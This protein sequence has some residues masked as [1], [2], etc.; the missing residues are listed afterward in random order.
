SVAGVECIEKALLASDYKNKRAR[1]PVVKGRT[2]RG[3]G[4]SAFMHG[5]GFTGSGARYLKGKGAIDRE[6]RGRLRSRTAATDNGRGTRTASAA[7]GEGTGTVFRQSAADAAGV[8]IEMVDFAV[9]CTTTCPDSGPTVA[10]RTVMVVGSIVE[11]AARE[12]GERVRME[13]LARGD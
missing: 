4:A 2:A 9:P 13:Q 3:I 6:A 1:G 7:M 11:A 10:S 12:I 8:P 5:A